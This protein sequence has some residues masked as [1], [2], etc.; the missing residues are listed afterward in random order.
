S[1][2]QTIAV[3]GTHGKTTV[4]TLIAHLLTQSKIGCSAFLGGISKNYDAN[5][6]TSDSSDWMVVEADEYDR[7]FLNLYPK[8]GIITSLDADHLDIYGDFENLKSSFR[9]FAEQIKNDGLLIIKKRI[10]LNP[11]QSTGLK[12][13]KYSINE[14]AD[15]YTENIRLKGDKYIFDLITPENQISGLELGIPGLINVENAV[16]A[17]AAAYLTGAEEHELKSAL[18]LFTGIHRRFDYKIKTE[19]LI[20]I[21]DY[22]HHPEE[23]KGIINSVREIYPEKTILGIFQ[24][25]LYSRTRDFTDEFAKSLDLLDEVILL[26]IYPAREKPIE[27]VNSELILNKISKQKKT[28]CSK[29]ELIHKIAAK[30][31][32]ILLTLGAGDIDQLVQPIQNYFTETRIKQKV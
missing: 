7:S 30:K 9:Q 17:L 8:I 5:L 20:Y 18:S 26:P 32:D 2:K 14:K 21:D 11:D 12:I 28:L 23:L 29:E 31:F 6:L 19:D 1:E 13:Y 10:E 3:A 22:A 4:T 15:F 24:P 25:H 16:A 27:G